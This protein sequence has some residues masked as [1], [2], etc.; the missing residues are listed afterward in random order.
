VHDRRVDTAA[1][2]GQR[3]AKTGGLILLALGLLGSA[4][5]LVI[6][7]AEP[8]GEFDVGRAIAPFVF[9]V[10]AP[11]LLTGVGILRHHRSAAILGILV[12]GL[13]G[14]VAVGQGTRAYGQPGLAV[15]GLGF[16]L[17]AAL[18]LDS[19]RRSALR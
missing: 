11:P 15:V 3:L 10:A 7:M 13:Y 12:G 2:P 5:G 8:T 16:L 4:Y 6:A 9:V 14:V 1:A 17:A 18:V 19:F